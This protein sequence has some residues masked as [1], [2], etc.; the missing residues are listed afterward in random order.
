MNDLFENEQKVTGHMPEQNIEHDR[1]YQ[2]VVS[3]NGIEV[4]RFDVS[5]NK[6][7]EI[8]LLENIKLKAED[9][10]EV[11]VIGHQEGKDDKESKVVST[12][13]QKKELATLL[14]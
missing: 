13:V 7:Y 14:N 8:T 4:G 10:V 3:V 9:T 2:L 6:D 5:A 12:I 1:N 11:T